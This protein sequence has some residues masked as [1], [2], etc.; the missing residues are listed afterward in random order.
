ML[1]HYGPLLPVSY[2]TYCEPFFGGGAMF[3]H[4]KNSNPNMTCY[5]ND[6]N[7]GIVNIYKAIRDDVTRFLDILDHIDQQYIPLDK[8]KR[9]EFYYNKIGRAHV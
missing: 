5:I 8:E 2:S 3:A 6:V 4:I 9:K 1:R 7:Q